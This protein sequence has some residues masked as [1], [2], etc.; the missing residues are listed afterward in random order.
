MQPLFEEFLR[1]VAL[2][3]QEGHLAANV[4]FLFI[5]TGNPELPSLSQ[6]A[7]SMKLG[8]SFREIPHRLSYLEVQQ[9]L[10]KAEGALIM[11]ST[12]AHYTASK[13]FQCLITARRTMA[14]FHHESEGGSILARCAA[15][16]FYQPYFPEMDRAE[17]IQSLSNTLVSFTSLE[18]PWEPDL[19][20][21]EEFSA[22]A[23]A[24]K[25][26]DAIGKISVRP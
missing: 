5:G 15:D 21:L 19:T 2:A 23:S 8:Q 1:A 14:Y 10:R 16:S 26:A 25:L 13:I 4:Q 6:L 20:P 11:G 22:K 3:K 9:I 17:R 7:Q 18:F 12:E 24:E